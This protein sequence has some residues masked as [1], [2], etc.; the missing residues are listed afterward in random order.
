MHRARAALPLLAAA[1]ALAGCGGGESD[2][3]APEPVGEEAALGDAAAML[4]ARRE[5]PVSEAS[6]TPKDGSE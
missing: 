4:D 5:E 2:M 3:P 6:P 1:V